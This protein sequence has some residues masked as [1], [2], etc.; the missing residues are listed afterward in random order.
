MEQSLGS[1]FKDNEYKGVSAINEY[2]LI[3]VYS[4]VAKGN[5]CE[6]F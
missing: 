4:A 3:N 1:L 6:G 5:S 2:S